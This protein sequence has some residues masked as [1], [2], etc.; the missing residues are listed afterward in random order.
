MVLLIMI[1]KKIMLYSPLILWTVF[2]YYLS[3]VPAR[4]IKTTIPDY[5]VHMI[6]YGILSLLIYRVV[7]AVHGESVRSHIGT[8]ICAIIFGVTDE[9]HQFFIPGRT[10][11]FRDL[12][13]DALGAGLMLWVLWKLLPKMPKFI[14]D[15][16]HA[17]LIPFK[18]GA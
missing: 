6:E 12:S 15:F 11:S 16:A 9:I 2:I 7:A 3:S 10:P 17:A 4:D 8:W 1:Q 5:V 14:K 13:F 18:S